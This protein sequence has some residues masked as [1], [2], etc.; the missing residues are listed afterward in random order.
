MTIH[1]LENYYSRF[2]SSLPTS[3]F[4][5]MEVEFIAMCIGFPVNQFNFTESIKDR[6]EMEIFAI[7]QCL[8]EIL[9][10]DKLGKDSIENRQ[11]VKVEDITMN[12]NYTVDIKDELANEVKKIAR[13]MRLPVLDNLYVSYDDVEG[14]LDERGLLTPMN[15]NTGSYLTGFTVR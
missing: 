4:E 1:P 8:K 15:R 11:V 2:G 3:E 13:L 10:L 7:R 6:T 9:R 12:M 5:Q 14:K